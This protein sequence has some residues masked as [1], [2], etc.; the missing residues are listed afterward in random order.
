MLKT[1]PTEELLKKSSIRIEGQILQSSNAAFLVSLEKEFYGIYKPE[2]FERHLWDFEPGLWKRE[3]SAYLFSKRFKL[4]NIPATVARDGP[5]GTGSVQLL[6]ESSDDHYLTLKDQVSYHQD[7]INIAI[8]D[9]IANN[10]DRKSGHVLR[11]LNNQIW[12]IDH[13]LCFN[14]EFKLRTV[15]W[16]FAGCQIPLENLEK[17]KSIT[18]SRLDFLNEYLSKSEILKII[19]RTRSLIKRGKLP[20]PH[21]PRPYP[22]PII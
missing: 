8:F 21:G 2:A 4:C 20:L 10:A 5:F 15:I 9:F 16:D 1:D 11:D 18:E 7:F 3:V 13:G 17:L 12:A 6:I 19:Q 22:W 14:E